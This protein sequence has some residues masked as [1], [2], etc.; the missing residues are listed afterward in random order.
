MIRRGVAAGAALLAIVGCKSGERHKEDAITVE[1]SRII[2]SLRARPESPLA[3]GPAKSFERVAGGLVPRFALASDA[4]ARLVLPAKASSP[5]RLEDAGS[6]ATIEFSLHGAREIAA[7]AAEGYLVYPKAHASGATLL[8]RALGEGTEDFVSFETRPP[9]AEIATTSRSARTSRASGSSRA[10]W[11]CST[12]G[13]RPG[14]AWRRLTSSGRTARGP[15]PSS[16][17]TAARSTRTR[18][19]PGAGRVTP[20]GAAPCTVRVTW[21]DD[22]V[23]YP[24]VLDPR[25]TTTANRWSRRAPTTRRRC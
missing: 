13:A 21:D 7:Q 5:I 1:A 11:R 2:S 16:R 15:T 23:V 20:P 25:W 14:C 9:V 12:P 22:A 6:G 4:S 8:H 24:A 18:P 10:R 3:V 17:W 19:R